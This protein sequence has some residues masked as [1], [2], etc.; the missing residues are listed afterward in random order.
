[1]PSRRRLLIAVF[2]TLAA[3]GALAVAGSGGPVAGH[4]QAAAAAQSRP[5]V[6]VIESDDQTVESMRVMNRVNSLIG[7]KG[8]TFKNNF[9]NFSLCCPSRATFLTGQYAHNHKVVD[10]APPDGGYPKFEPLHGNNNLAVW[11]QNA[12]YNTAM[13]GK[14]LSYMKPSTVPPGWSDWHAVVQGSE[15]VYGYTMNDNGTLTNYGQKPTDFLDDVLTSKAVNYIDRTRAQAEPVLPL[16]H[17]HGPARERPGSESEPTVRLR[18]RLE[19]GASQRPRVRHRAVAAAPELQRGGRLR[20]AGRDQEPPGHERDPDRE[21]AAPLPLRARVASS[22]WTRAC[23]TVVDALN[24]DR[25]ARKHPGRVHL[26]QRLP[27]RRAQALPGARGTSTR[28]R[29]GC[30]SR[31]AARASRRE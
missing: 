26:G 27:Q 6:V 14:Y 23:R 12:G 20:Q 16:A 25:P 4:G 11:L 18:R 24:G 13:I 21:H 10:N 19:A 29:S 28:S 9:V 2:A 3:T 31:C 1:M 5:N 7:D 30:R 8:A 17:L 22:P 15:K